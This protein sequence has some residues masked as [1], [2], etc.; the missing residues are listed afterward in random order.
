MFKSKIQ[1]LL[2]L[3]PIAICCWMM[4]PLHGMVFDCT[5]CDPLGI[6]LLLNFVLIIWVLFI[7]IYSGIVFSKKLTN[8]VDKKHIALINDLIEKFKLV[9]EI[10][11]PN[12]E[13]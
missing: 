6:G 13:N 12:E 1:I 10:C 5:N 9:E 8:E 4:Y 2:F 11:R 7:L 3:I